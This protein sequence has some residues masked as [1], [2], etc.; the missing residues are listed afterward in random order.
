MY[1]NSLPVDIKVNA[2]YA[3]CR[4]VLNNRFITG[5]EPEFDIIYKL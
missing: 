2:S 5:R 1:L 4:T 3:R